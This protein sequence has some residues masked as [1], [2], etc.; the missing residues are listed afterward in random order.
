VNITTA[1]TQDTPTNPTDTLTLVASS[2]TTVNISGNAGLNLTDTTNVAITSLDAS[3]ISKGDFT[4]TSAALAGAAAIKGS[5]TGVNTVT[6]SAAANGAVTYTGGTGNDVITASNGKNN[7]ISLGDGTNSVTGA[8]G[9]NTI[10][11]GAGADTVTLTTG[12]NVVNLGNGANAF[13]ATTGNNTYVGGTGVDTI[14]VG[15]GLNTIAGARGN[16]L[17]V[18]GR[19]GA[20]WHAEVDPPI[21]FARDQGAPWGGAR[22]TVVDRAANRGACGVK[23][24]DHHGFQAG[25]FSGRPCHRH[26]GFGRDSSVQ[27]RRCVVAVGF[28]GPIQSHLNQCD[29]MHQDFFDGFRSR[30]ST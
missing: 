12:N 26:D 4:F 13:T 6:F 5:A 17:G 2:A 20:C 23:L 9:N 27:R 14:S 25:Q 22:A 24:G 16:Q 28:A 18:G 19:G 30:A 3:G 1:D 29:A 15:G 8:A 11:G 7:I 10:T 21:F